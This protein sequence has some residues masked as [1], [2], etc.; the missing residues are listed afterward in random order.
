MREIDSVAIL[1]AGDMG[2]QLAALLAQAGLRV[3]LLD[4]PAPGERDRNVKAQQALAR[5]R[6]QRPAPLF[7]PV[8]LRLIEVGNVED[9]LA[10]LRGCGWV[11]EAL[12][13][14]PGVK[15]LLLQQV[16]I[17]CAADALVST[18][19]T[20][21]S[22]AALAEA[23]P[24]ESRPFFLGVHFF[25]PPRYCYLV[26]LVGLPESDAR[27]LD[28]VERFCD[29][30]LGKGVL[31]AKDTPGFIATRVAGFYHA[32]AQRLAIE[33]ELPLEL[34]D[35]LSGLLIGSARVGSFRFADSLGWDVWLAWLRN[36]YERLEND[37]A[38][39]YW[40]PHAT[41]VELV[42]QHELGRRSGR[43][44]FRLNGSELAVRVL[45][46]GG[47]DYIA[48]RPI[49]RALEELA[50]L[51]LPTRI[52][53]AIDL[54]G[55]E[56]QYAW[57]LISEYLCYAATVVTEIAERVADVDR[58]ARWGYGF[59]LGPF[60]TWDA[61]GVWELARRL[62]KDSR[63]VPETVLTLLRTGA[64][65]FYRPADER[66]RPQMEC[67]DFTLRRYRRIVEPPGILGLVDL[68]RTSVVLR[69]SPRVTLVDLGEQVLGVDLS[70]TGEALDEQALDL[71]EQA[72]D[73]LGDRFLALVLTSSGEAFCGGLDFRAVA[74]LAEEGRWTELEHWIARVQRWLLRARRVTFPIVAAIHRY[75]CG[76]GAEL[77]LIAG[78]VLTT[79]ELYLGFDE[80][81]VGLI[82]IGTGLMRALNQLPDPTPLWEHAL[83]GRLTTSAAEAVERR[84]LSVMPYV[85]PNPRRLLLAARAEAI[86]AAATFQPSQ[87]PLQLP[88]GG[89]VGYA[90]L[91]LQAWLAFRAGR[92]HSAQLE[93][94]TRFA[95]IANG[96]TV[97]PCELPESHLMEQA[98]ET[99][100]SLCG[101]AEVRQLLAKKTG[102]SES[103]K[104]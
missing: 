13:E 92:I 43:G 7:S 57:K 79:R 21:L 63:A 9:D 46:P 73:W 31:R 45:Q 62:E 47:G 11:I 25:H 100:L 82:P 91:R 2:A 54:P 38:R 10:K 67:F 1:G 19:T 44:F 81:S 50:E 3:L 96:G 14:E 49:P 60:Q 71:L 17:F 85:V 32:L 76:V 30:R 80:F 51:P 41:L 93:A 6:A 88:V 24:E 18:C 64:R 39:R 28:W 27:T 94:A 103:F 75:A 98:R 53:R 87:A 22:V 58:A 26:E 33:Q 101:T 29:Q 104:T 89:E 15:R 42:R 52:G 12:P 34:A 69:Q 37:P 97:S 74:T 95:A 72:L 4:E 20:S 83:A 68:K 84:Y 35:W 90:R 86:A 59:G 55:P 61:L 77:G 36:L 66:G 78:R 56:G 65:T 5:L 40:E 23:L 48:A 102:R 70:P 99:F 8:D 16:G